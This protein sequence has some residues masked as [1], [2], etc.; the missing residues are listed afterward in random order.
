MYKAAQNRVSPVVHVQDLVLDQQIDNSLSQSLSYYG[1]T[2]ASAPYPNHVFSPNRGQSR[3]YSL[4][5]DLSARFSQLDD[6]TDTL[7]AAG[8]FSPTAK[9]GKVDDGSKPGERNSF[10]S[11]F[12]TDDETSI[13]KYIDEIKE[14]EKGGVEIAKPLKKKTSKQKNANS[15]S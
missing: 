7:S 10:S 8:D 6:Y 1:V 15:V 9:Y 14:T 3:E 13:S 2:P 12:A 5:R 11:S 4:S